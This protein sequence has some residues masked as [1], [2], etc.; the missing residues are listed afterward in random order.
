MKKTVLFVLIF[1]G[2]SV[3]LMIAGGSFRPTSGVK[4]DLGGNKTSGITV[5]DNVPEKPAILAAVEVA[6]HNSISDCWMIINGKIYDLTAFFS[7]HPGGAEAISRHC[8]TD[9]TE[10]YGTKDKNETDG[11]SSYAK[12]LLA[13]Y[14]LGDLNGA[15][16]EEKI[17]MA[18]N[19]DAEGNTGIKSAIENEKTPIG[20]SVAGAGGI[21]SAALAGHNSPSDCWMAL[22]GKV[23]D[24]TAY[25]RRHPG[26]DA[27]LAYC[28]RDGT[29]AFNGRG[30]SDYARSLLPA[31]YIGDFGDSAGPAPEISGGQTRSGGLSAVEK[32]YPGA[33]ILE[34][35]IEDDG[36]RE[37]KLLY[38]GRQ[39]EVR[40]GPGGDILRTEDH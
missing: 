38:E 36:R 3:S 24:V 17:R 39:Y 23:Y 27:M 14:Y 20:D 31:Y 2:I 33:I 5:A 18:E 10:A 7:Q 12:S 11:H 13:D 1:F 30:H 15:L 35:N 6:K 8:G 19:K 40:V 4:I 26:G 9:G 16:P 22:S 34:E 28:G 29:T 25:L 21:T 32:E 37:I